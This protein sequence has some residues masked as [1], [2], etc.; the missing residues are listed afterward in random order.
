MI[1]H[2]S[3]LSGWAVALLAVTASASADIKLNDNLTFSGYAAGSYM[4]YKASGLPSVDSL[5]DASKPIPGGGDSNDVL[6]KFT[7]NYKPVTAVVSLNYFPNIS[8]SEFTVLDAYVAYDAGEGVTITGGK[9]LSNLGYESFYP[10]NMDQISYANGDFLAPIPG[11]HSGV[12]V[13]FADKI[14]GVG[15]ALVDSVYSPYG[16]TRGDG[17]LKH[18]AGLEGYYT[19]TGI[20]DVTLWAG[21]AYDSKGGFEPHS[22]MTYDFWA[23]Y[24]ATK[25]LKLAAEFV[26]KDGGLGSKGTNWITFANYSFS[27]KTTTTFRISGEEMSNGGPKFTKYT[28]AP[29]Y[30]LTANLTVRAEFSHYSYSRYSVNE[31]PVA[32]ANFFGLQ[33]IF[34]F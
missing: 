3:R 8:S 2:S 14:Q 5:F 31:M 28:I 22:V 18:N 16:G 20:S 30:A 29:A 9:F 24:Q 25:A 19:Y 21:F 33:A 32:S 10:A 26:S 6:T 23:S 1:K 27:D 12:K 13:D 4:N 7:F 11:Y 15:V 34:K 17:E